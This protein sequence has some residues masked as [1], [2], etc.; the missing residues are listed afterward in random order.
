MVRR[1]FITFSSWTEPIRSPQHKVTLSRLLISTTLVKK[2]YHKQSI[3]WHPDRFHANSDEELKASATR[4]FQIISKAYTILSDPEKRSVYNETGL[5]EDESVFDEN[6]DWQVYWRQMF[7]KVTVQEIEAFLAKYKGSAEQVEDVKNNYERFKGNLN[8][9]LECTIGGDNEDQIR[10][11]IDD[12]IATGQIRV[13]S[14]L[15]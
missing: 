13:D 10:L 3:I 15:I 14:F 4:R 5:I 12:L 9:I 7:K 6:M 1:I 2:A 11:I 8:K